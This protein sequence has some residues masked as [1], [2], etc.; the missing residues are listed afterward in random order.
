[1]SVFLKMRNVHEDLV[2]GYFVVWWRATLGW[3]PA[4]FN[5]MFIV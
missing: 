4:L 5:T 1:M 2:G 3:I